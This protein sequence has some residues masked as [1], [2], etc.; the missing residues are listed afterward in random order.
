M[1]GVKMYSNKEIWNVTYPI[2]LGLFAQNVINVTD[3][4]FLGHVGEV[5]LGAAAMGG[6]LYI[7][8]YTVAFGFSVGSQILIA[9]RNG[10]GNYREVGPIML[11][12][13]MF[14]LLMALGFLLILGFSSSSVIRLLVSSDSICQ[15]TC[16]F[17]SW[18]MWG[19]VFSF[20]ICMFRS[21]YIGITRT[22]ALT[23]ASIVMAVANI[24]LDYAL[25]F[26]E[27]GFPQMGVRGAALASVVAEALA[28]AFLVLYTRK[29]VD[30]RK[31]GFY[32][33]LN[34][35]M[36]IIGKILKISF[37][38]MVQYFLSMGVWFVFFVAIERLGQRELAI[39]N[40]VRSIYIVLLIPVQALATTANT[41]V[42][43]LIGSGG[44]SN[45]MRLLN[46][47]SLV[48]LL[49]MVVCVLVSLVF[50]QSILGIYTSDASL[51]AESLPALYVVLGAMLIA[52][53]SNIYFNGI[54]GTGNTQAALVLET[55]IL[56]FYALYVVLVGW[57]LRQPVEICY[58]TE[59]VYYSLMLIFSVVY[60]KKAKWQNKK[61]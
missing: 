9:R 23:Y 34:F 14:S 22:K 15:A 27:F 16:Q 10:E 19:F 4:A 42:S 21:L 41:L 1:N 56:I 52:S 13:C 2:L 55:G 54:S 20:L 51:V 30:L 47:I 58:T 24:F 18:R 6:L 12:G 50:P 32:R 29:V 28:L 36:H 61:I 7:C 43:N 53:V 31:Y 45:V 44:V 49:I 5:A 59:F 46:R 60:L 33:S 57:I 35:D 11:Q 25:I 40:I 38:T 3:T 8:I 39:A 37:F 17:F 26:G 48:S